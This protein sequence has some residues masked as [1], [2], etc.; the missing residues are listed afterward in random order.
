MGRVISQPFGKPHKEASAPP[1]P[2]DG[3]PR[4]TQLGRAV[5]DDNAMVSLV[6]DVRSK[7]FQTSWAGTALT[8]FVDDVFTIIK[9]KEGIAVDRKSV[10]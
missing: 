1:I 3:M 6:N 7:M 10:V 9:Q 2:T 5:V 4:S 8:A